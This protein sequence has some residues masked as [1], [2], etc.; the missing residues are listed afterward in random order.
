MEF[1]AF[2]HHLE[3]NWKIHNIFSLL[4]QMGHHFSSLGFNGVERQMD[5]GGQRLI[6][7]RA[8]RTSSHGSIAAVRPSPWT[9]RIIIIWSSRDWFH[10]WFLPLVR[11]SVSQSVKG[12]PHWQVG[13]QSPHAPLTR[14][15]FIAA[16]VGKSWFR[17]YY[18]SITSV[19]YTTTTSIYCTNCSW[20]AHNERMVIDV[21][22]G[23]TLVIHTGFHNSLPVSK[24]F[25]WR[26]WKL[27][28]FEM[29]NWIIQSYMLL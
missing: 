17:Y 12:N 16:V 23:L 5:P 25:Y 9:K 20:Q 11:Q 15:P 8:P 10:P 22:H 28:F 27:S 4:C 1:N 6:T 18:Y 24:A 14:L 13:L 3:N 21:T 26:S 19:L 2:G 29:N 7:H